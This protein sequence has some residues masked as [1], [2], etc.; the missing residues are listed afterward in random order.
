MSD[1]DDLGDHDVNFFGDESDNTNDVYDSLDIFESLDDSYE[2]SRHRGR[3]LLD[4]SPEH[5]NHY[6]N[7]PLRHDRQHTPPIV[8][9]PRPI[10]PNNYMVPAPPPLD[11]HQQMDDDSQGVIV[12]KQP[13][14]QWYQRGTDQE[15]SIQSRTPFS[16]Y[17]LELMFSPSLGGTVFEPVCNTR[18]TGN[19][20]THNTQNDTRDS[21]LH[22]TVRP[23]IDVC[24]RKGERMFVLQLTLSSGHVIRSRPFSVKNRQPK[25]NTFKSDAKRAIQQLE[26]CPTTQACHMCLHTAIDGHSTTCLIRKL[27]YTDRGAR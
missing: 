10:M 26:W 14:I 24:T 19:G 4:E 6:Q 13:P 5:L 20:L 22:L 23:K 18:K 15:F 12:I 27:L 25:P 8:A 21:S 11:P 9:A 17:K 7:D 1:N 16:T 3:L 2:K